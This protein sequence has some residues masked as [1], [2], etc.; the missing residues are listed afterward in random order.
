MRNDRIVETWLHNAANVVK[1]FKK[2]ANAPGANPED[3]K[4]CLVSIGLMSVEALPA[5]S[6]LVS[7]LRDDVARESRF[8]GIASTSNQR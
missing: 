7:S 2:L 8:R 3:V 1:S 6:D 4:D 5:I